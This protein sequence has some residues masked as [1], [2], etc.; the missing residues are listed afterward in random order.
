MTCFG[1]I[2][3]YPRVERIFGKVDR[4]FFEL[5]EH[6][7]KARLFD[8]LLSVLVRQSVQLRSELCPSSC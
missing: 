6:I 5:K 7:L 8:Q 1:F 3:R 2:L 4:T